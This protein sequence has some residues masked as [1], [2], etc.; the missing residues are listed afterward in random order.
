VPRAIIPRDGDAFPFAQPQAE[1]ESAWHDP[2]FVERWKSERRRRFE[3]KILR[4]SKPS[5]SWREEPYES[6]D[7]AIDLERE[8]FGGAHRHAQQKPKGD[9]SRA[10]P[11]AFDE[12]GDFVE[13]LRERIPERQASQARLLLEQGLAGKA[14]RQAWCGLVGRRRDCFSGN[15]EHRFYTP[16]LCGN[17]YCAT[18]GPKSFRDL[19][20]H[21]SRLRPLAEFL[22]HH[23]P[24]DH[25]PRVLAKLDI[26]T[27]NVGEMP[28]AE[29][30]RQFN[31]DIRRFFRAIE[32][33]FG[34]LRREYGVL[35]CCEFG[36]GHTNLHAHGVYAGPY[37][38]QRELSRIWSEVRADGSFIVSIK[39]ARSFE[40]ALGHALKYPSKFF[41]ASPARLVELEVAFDRVR[42]VHALAAFYNPK[43]EREPGEDGPAE[44]G[45]CPI[46]GDLLLDA[47]GYHFISDLQSEG[48]RAVDAVRVDVARA[49][50]L[51]ESPP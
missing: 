35:W 15:S 49:R 39:K 29:E 2:A 46:C 33:E 42:R 3:R 50:V 13:P 8:E 44:A 38:P 27:R 43:I 41:D 25:R 24:A 22:L 51:A 16:C 36:S 1:S 5:R 4:E 12:R 37:L 47:P 32:R 18:C 17:R 45:H 48:R 34:I 26:T 14:R 11:L 6:Q 30:V 28:T 10:V 31:K 23:R 7:R 9:P 21:H 40:A 19:F 20:T